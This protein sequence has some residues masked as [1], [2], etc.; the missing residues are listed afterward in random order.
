MRINTHSRYFPH[1][2]T[3][4]L[5]TAQAAKRLRVHIATVARMVADGR[6]EAEVKVPGKRGA[7]LF[8][9]ST[10]DAFK[11]KLLDDEAKAEA[12]GA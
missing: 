11:Q 2:R 4:L 5:T 12:E 10:I 3:G 7:Y 8:D 6:L 1:M 9:P